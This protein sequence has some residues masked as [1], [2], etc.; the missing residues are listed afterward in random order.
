MARNI[1]AKDLVELLNAG[2][3]GEIDAP[4]PYERLAAAR[5]GY[6]NSALTTRGILGL[7]YDA[8]ENTFDMQWASRI[9]LLVPADAES[10]THRWVGQTPKMREWLGGLLAKGLNDFGVTV[11]NR[12]FEGTIEILSLIHI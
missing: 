4:R 5:G 7:F 11:V 8:L 3:R 1:T 9:G 6:D 12:D 10:Q 2:I